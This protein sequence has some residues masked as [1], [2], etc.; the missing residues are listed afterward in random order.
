MA[1]DGRGL[2]QAQ[3]VFEGNIAETK[4]FARMLDG[5]ALPSGRRGSTE[6]RGLT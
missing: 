3:E 1:F 4:T 5:L 2:A 6:N